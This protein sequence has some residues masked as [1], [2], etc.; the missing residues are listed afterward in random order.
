MIL[1]SQGL[2]SIVGSPRVYAAPAGALAVFLGLQMVHNPQKSAW[3]ASY[4]QT[5][6]L[7]AAAHSQNEFDNLFCLSI[8][9]SADFSMGTGDT[10]EEAL[11]VVVILTTTTFALSVIHRSVTRSRHSSQGEV[12][13][14]KLCGTPRRSRYSCLAFS[15]CSS[16][17][18]VLYCE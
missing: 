17:G 5:F 14:R 1:S 18:A 2:Q 3:P 15:R 10:M 13:Q 8:S 16:V 6:L 12:V 9:K 4:S 11:L 7:V